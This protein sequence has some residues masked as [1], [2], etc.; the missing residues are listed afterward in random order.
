M[1]TTIVLVT[2]PGVFTAAQGNLAAAAAAAAAAGYPTADAA[3]MDAAVAAVAAAQQQQAMVQ[4]PPPP[5]AN[6]VPGNL[7][8]AIFLLTASQECVSILTTEFLKANA[9]QVCFTNQKFVVQIS[10]SR[11]TLVDHNWVNFFLLCESFFFC[12]FLT[13]NYHFHWISLITSQMPSNSV[14]IFKTFKIY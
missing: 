8:E 3:R 10:D 9:L 14:K 12:K 6:P 5:P 11:S 4:P 13:N 7:F 2:T 1:W